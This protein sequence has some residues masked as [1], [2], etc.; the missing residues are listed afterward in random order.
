MPSLVHPTRLLCSISHLRSATP[1]APPV[2]IPLLLGLV[3]CADENS[4]LEVQ[5]AESQEGVQEPHNT[6]YSPQALRQARQRIA[7]FIEEMIPPPYDET[8][9]LHDEW[10][11][12]TQAKMKELQTGDVPL[13][14]AALQAFAADETDRVITRK[15]LLAI[16]S[17]C[18]PASA[19]PLLKE[20]AGTFGYRIDDRTEA[21]LLLAEVSPTDYQE[22]F[23]DHLG[24]R[25]RPRQT[26]PPDEFLLEGWIQSCELLG[27]SA[28]EMCSDVSTNIL[29]E[30][31]ARYRAVQALAKY[32]DEAL[33]RNALM[34]CLIEST[35]D[36]Y[37]RRKAAQAIRIS[38]NSEEACSL[39]LDTLSKEADPDFA[40]FLRSTIQ[41]MGCR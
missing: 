12:R 21:A 3:A 14:D 8:S 2:L 29:I 41:L 15:A 32:K 19:R 7:A 25:A 35:G 33:A 36:A 22:L 1:H 37:L 27:E 40:E 23:K 34:T 38:F 9:D 18:S 13:G 30:P 39:F 26:M 10:F 16:G 24:R 6:A 4:S 5:P 11:H 31:A 17:R 20:L 28:L